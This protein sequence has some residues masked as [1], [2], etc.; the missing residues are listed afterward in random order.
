MIN[1]LRK[2]SSKQLSGPLTQ[3]TPNAHPE[4]SPRTAP[5]SVPLTRTLSQ[6]SRIE[7]SHHSRSGSYRQQL[8]TLTIPKVRR[9]SLAASMRWKDTDGHEQQSAIDAGEL[10]FAQRLVMANENAVTNIA[11]LWVAAAMSSDIESYSQSNSEAASMAD[12]VEDES[13]LTRP[14]RLLTRVYLQNSLHKRPSNPSAVRPGRS[15]CRQSVSP[16]PDTSSIRDISPALGTGSV[17][18]FSNP[19]S[20]IFTNPGVSSTITSDMRSILLHSDEAT[21]DLLAPIIED[22]R[23]FSPQG[24]TTTV[25]LKAT[26]STSITSQLPVLIIIQY[27]LLAL[28]STTYDQM[29]MSY[30]VSYVTHIFAN[31]F[32]DKPFSEYRYGGLSLNAGHFAQLR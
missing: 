3:Y 11:D 26:Q 1:P 13:N 19:A 22:Q 10:N 29:F 31:A 12:E 17:H 6:S 23:L 21:G 8:A 4:L 30:L 25:E 9:S 28:H 32:L 5:L 14:G 15:Q 24:T 2:K 7:G 16:P 27:G 18:R 20:I